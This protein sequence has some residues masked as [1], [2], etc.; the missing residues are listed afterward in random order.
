MRAIDQV[1][2]AE[3][4]DPR[5]AL[6]LRVNERKSVRPDPCEGV[7]GGDVNGG[8]LSRSAAGPRCCRPTGQGG[9]RVR[10][11]ASPISPAKPRTTMTRRGCATDRRPAGRRL[12]SGASMAARTTNDAMAPPRRPGGRADQLDEDHHCEDSGCR[13]PRPV[14]GT[15]A[16]YHH[17]RQDHGQI[18]PQVVGVAEGREISLENEPRCQSMKSQLGPWTSVPGSWIRP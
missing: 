15:D 4:G 16:E 8:L 10:E 7:V 2:R 17:G 13:P 18:P 6:V 1:V 14:L 9:Q 11:E 12:I 3:A 5:R